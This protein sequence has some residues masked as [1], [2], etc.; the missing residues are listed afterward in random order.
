MYLEKSHT[1]PGTVHIRFAPVR[2]MI[3]DNVANVRRV[4]ADLLEAVEELERRSALSWKRLG[5]P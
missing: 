3:T 1:R 5:D 2:A 4:L